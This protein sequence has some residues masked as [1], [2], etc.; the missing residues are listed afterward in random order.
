[1]IGIGTTAVGDDGGVAAVR[2]PVDKDCG[3]RY[4]ILRQ[5]LDRLVGDVVDVFC[6][7]DDV[8]GV[9]L[10]GFHRLLIKKPT[11]ETDYPRRW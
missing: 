7:Y 5:E 9:R 3:V 6:L 4:G 2:A 1:M 11:N 10:V 8:P